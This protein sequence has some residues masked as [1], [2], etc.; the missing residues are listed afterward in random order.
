MRGRKKRKRNHFGKVVLVLILLGAIVAGAL[1]FGRD[2]LFPEDWNKDVVPAVEALQ[3]RSGLEFKDPV[4]VN[5][6]SEAE[7][8]AKVAS[9]VFGPGLAAEWQPSIPRWRALGLVDGDPTLESVNGV[10][11]RG[12][13]RSTIRRTGRSS[14]APPAPSPSPRGETCEMRCLPP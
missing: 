4:S 2:Y 1:M 7:Y 6:L 12:C 13:R 9:F 5:T 3:L 8:A 10:V 14:A 11:T